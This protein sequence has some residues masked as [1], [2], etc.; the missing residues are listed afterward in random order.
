LPAGANVVTPQLNMSNPYNNEQDAAT[1]AGNAVVAA[2]QSTGYKWEYGAFWAQV[3]NSW[4]ATFA[5]TSHW[6]TGVFWDPDTL[7][8]FFK[9]YIVLGYTHYHVVPALGW[10]FSGADKGTASD[11]A[12]EESSFHAF[13]LQYQ[14]GAYR[15]VN[16]E[17]Y[18]CSG[19]VL[20]TCGP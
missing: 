8:A 3:G 1:G 11:W 15:L 6:P 12:S 9:D 14:Y 20:L 17:G 16:G 4:Y 10:S 19:G 2:E 18:K 5:V 7:N 13:F